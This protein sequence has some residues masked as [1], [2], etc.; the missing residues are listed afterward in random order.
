MRGI[1]ESGVK[2]IDVCTG[3]MEDNIGIVTFGGGPE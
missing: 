3:D 2:I 1:G